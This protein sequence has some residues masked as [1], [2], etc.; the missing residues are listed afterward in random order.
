MVVVANRLPFDLQ[1]L[2]DGSTKARQ[3]PG[4]LVTAFAPILSKRE[5]A[6]IGWPG[7]PDED[8]ESHH[9]GRAH[10]VSCSAERRGGRGYYEGFSN[11]TLWPLYHDAVADSEFHRQWWESYRQVNRRFAEARPSVAA[12]A[13]RCGCTTTSCN[14]S[15]DAPRAAARRPDRLL[16]AHPVPAGGTVRPAAVAHADHHG[17][18]GADLVGFQLPGGARNFVRLARQLAG[19]ATSGSAI[20]FEGRDDPRRGVPDLHRLRGP[21][22]LAT[23]PPVTEAAANLRARAGRSAAGSSSASTGWTT[24][25]AS[26][27]GCRPS[28]SCWRPRIPRSRTR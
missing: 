28:R 15:R 1:K 20:E 7:Q 9:H 14:W 3:A 24:P 16:P 11:A 18:L 10:P 19:A 21:S 23:S 27:S 6:W 17:L 4:G 5:G 2:T 22:Q 25:R 26:T 13:R 12:R 8:P